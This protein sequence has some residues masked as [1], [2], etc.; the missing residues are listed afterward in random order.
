[1]TV[2]AHRSPLDDHD[3]WRELREQALN[4]ELDEEQRRD[5]RDRLGWGWS[6]EEAAE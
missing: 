4:E 2:A 1:M 3:R 5:E 6:E